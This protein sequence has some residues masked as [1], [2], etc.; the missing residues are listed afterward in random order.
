M[1]CTKFLYLEKT[2]SA[3]LYLKNLRILTEVIRRKLYVKVLVNKI[4]F[5]VI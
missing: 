2:S 5:K 1:F 4:Y 3:K